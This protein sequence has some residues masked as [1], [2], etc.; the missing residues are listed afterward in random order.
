M[1]QGVSENVN[2]YL[3]WLSQC[4]LVIDLHPVHCVPPTSCTVAAGSRHQLL[5][6]WK[7]EGGW[8][9]GV[10]VWVDVVKTWALLDCNLFPKLVSRSQETS[11]PRRVTV[12]NKVCSIHEDHKNLCA[13]LWSELLDISSKVSWITLRPNSFVQLVF[14]HFFIHLFFDLWPKK[15]FWKNISVPKMHLAQKGYGREE[16]MIDKKQY[17]VFGAHRI[18]TIE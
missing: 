13:L 12:H 2:A 8:G 10:P 5:A 9:W 3:Y 18:K 14:H 16:D 4:V 11:S 17:L 7:R 15:I 1:S 6:T